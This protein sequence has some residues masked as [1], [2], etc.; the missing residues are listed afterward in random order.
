M[1]ILSRKSIGWDDPLD[2]VDKG[3]WKRWLDDLPKLQEVQ[4]ERCLKQKGFG[5][6]AVA[7]LRLKDVSNR[8]HCAFVMVKARLAPI[9]EISI[10][11]LELTSR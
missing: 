1:Q 2:E 8:I 4:V 3:Q 9:R 7:Y 5:Y 10:P 6:A 11:R